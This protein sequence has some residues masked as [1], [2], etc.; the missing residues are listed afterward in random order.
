MELIFVLGNG[1]CNPEILRNGRLK[2]EIAKMKRGS[3]MTFHGKG[4]NYHV[5]KDASTMI[6]VD[7]DVPPDMN[8]TP[9]LVKDYN[10]KTKVWGGW[11][12][13]SI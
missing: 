11:K 2:K 1:S 7:N 10:K 13:V 9:K 12:R 3:Y 4:I 6:V 8:L 5:F